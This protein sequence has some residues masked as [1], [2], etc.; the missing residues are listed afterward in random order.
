MLYSID[1]IDGQWAVIISENDGAALTIPVCTLPAGTKEGS[2]I[3]EEGG[4][5][6]LDSNR[7]DEKRH[8]VYDR[9][10]RLSKG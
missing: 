9:V 4:A 6:T 2:I 7:S 1:R 5:Y 10:R 8:S 3:I